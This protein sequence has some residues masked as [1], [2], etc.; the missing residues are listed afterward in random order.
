MTVPKEMI[1]EAVVRALLDLVKAVNSSGERCVGIVAVVS[2]D[3]AERVIPVIDRNVRSTAHAD[4][5]RAL[6]ELA[7]VALID[8]VETYTTRDVAPKGEN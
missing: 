3:G 4:P 1:P 8:T 6:L 7:A 5:T 2:F